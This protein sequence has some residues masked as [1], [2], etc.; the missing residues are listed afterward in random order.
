MSIN[1]VNSKG[2][3][4]RRIRLD[5]FKYIEKEPAVSYAQVNAN[6]NHSHLDLVRVNPDLYG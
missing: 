6:E 3:D 2:I 5:Q 1:R 4:N